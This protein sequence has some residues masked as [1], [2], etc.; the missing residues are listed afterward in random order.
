MLSYKVQTND[1]TIGFGSQVYG[2]DTLFWTLF[3]TSLK[4]VKLEFQIG[5]KVDGGSGEASS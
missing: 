3:A 4:A 2:L 5:E 1:D